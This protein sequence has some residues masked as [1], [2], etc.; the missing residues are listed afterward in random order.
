MILTAASSPSSRRC[1]SPQ[2]TTSNITAR[3]DTLESTCVEYESSINNRLAELEL[4]RNDH[5]VDDRDARVAAL[6][7]AA[8]DVNA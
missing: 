6:E 5:V 8:K 1:R 3:L 7:N 2:V 4:T